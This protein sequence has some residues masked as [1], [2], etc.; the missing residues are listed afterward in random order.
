MTLLDTIKYSI[1]YTIASILFYTGILFVIKTFKLRNKVVI[2]MYHRVLNHN[3]RLATFSHPGICVDKD[4]FEQ[5][6][7]FLKK[8]FRVLPEDDFLEHLEESIPFHSSSCLITFDDGWLDN[9]TNAFPLLKENNFPAT[10]FL[11][12]DYIGTGKTFWQEKIAAELFDLLRRGD[13]S[14]TPILE[15]YDL[16]EV[17]ALPRW[18]AKIKIREFISKQKHLKSGELHEFI[19]DFPIASSS[20]SHTDKHV[21]SFLD[22]NN[23]REMA[24]NNISFGSHSVHHYILTNIP[25]ET[26]ATEIRDSQKAVEKGAGRSPKLFCYPNGNFSAEIAEEVR[27]A[28][29]LAALSTKQ[30]YLD[31]ESDRFSLP[32]IN[33]HD[34]TSS[35]IPLFMMRILGLF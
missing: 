26:A 29:Y 33:I 5:Q 34:G 15:H 1:K 31:K 12:T 21:D 23:V 2:L 10:I 16:G 27:A 22:W 30:G 18:Q 14:A 4:T 24:E 6:L 9:Y 35:S 32:R 3:E 25:H 7:L 20:V 11:A 19:D 13:K 17:A 28:G 8:H